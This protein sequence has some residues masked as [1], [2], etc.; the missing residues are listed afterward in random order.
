MNT[1]ANYRLSATQTF[2]ASVSLLA[3]TVGD[4]TD[5]QAAEQAAFAEPKQAVEALVDALR[6]RDDAAITSVLGDDAK[7]IIDSGDPVEDDIAQQKFVSAYDEKSSLVNESPEKVTLNV[8]NDDWPFPIPLV[9]KASGWQFDTAEGRDEILARRIGANE[10]NTIAASRAFVDAQREYATFDRD[11]DGILEYAQKFRSTDGQKD[12]LFWS[13]ETDPTPSPLGP[14]FASAQA[15]G[16]DVKAAAREE[17]PAY[18]GYRYRILTKQGANAEGGVTD[19]MVKDNLMGGF[20]MIAFPANYGVTGVKTFVVNHD[21][22]VFEADLGAETTQIAENMNVFDPD[23]AMWT[24][25]T[26]TEADAPG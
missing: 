3:L 8:G 13:E 14:L 6:K 9:K 2:L 21:A 19:Y 11:G 23:P 25:T 17:K 20:A 16:Y 1:I 18:Y 7:D 12:G 24:K 4:P 10:L 26:E 5:A 15:A 22:T